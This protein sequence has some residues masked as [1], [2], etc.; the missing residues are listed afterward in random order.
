MAELGNHESC[1]CG[2]EKSIDV[3]SRDAF[4]ILQRCTESLD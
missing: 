3:L 2:V 1:E 4:I